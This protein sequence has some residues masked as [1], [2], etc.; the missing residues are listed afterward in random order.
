LPPGLSDYA[1]TLHEAQDGTNKIYIYGGSLAGTL[2]NT[3]YSIR[4]EADGSLFPVVP[5]VT[6]LE[7]PTAGMAA[8][9]ILIGSTEYT[10]LTGGRRLNGFVDNS[11]YRAH[12]TEQSYYIVRRII[13]A[14]AYYHVNN[15]EDS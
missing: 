13:G 6:T 12:V 10:Y 11:T 15:N 1:I 8:S 2:Q 7:A 9:N 4:I 3:I 5:S 14:G